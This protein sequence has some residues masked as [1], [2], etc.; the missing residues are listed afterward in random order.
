MIAARHEGKQYSVSTTIGL[1]PPNTR[2]FDALFDQ[3]FGTALP[4]DRRT[5]VYQVAQDFRPLWTLESVEEFEYCYVDLLETHFHACDHGRVLHGDISGSNAMARRG[6][7]GKVYGLLIDWDLSCI[8][9]EADGNT[10]SIPHL[11]TGTTSFMAIDL[12]RTASRIRVAPDHRYCHDLESFF[13]LLLWAVLHFDLKKKRHRN[14]THEEWIGCCQACSL[15]FK[16]DFMSYGGTW[17]RVLNDALNMWQSVV[18]R[19][20]KPLARMI[21]TARERSTHWND[22]N[23]RVFDD[24]VYAKELTFDV[25][26]QTIKQIPSK[27]MQKEK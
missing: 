18:K 4:H 10:S 27:R 17:D 16:R 20:V 13:W 24:D 21:Y 1:E 8:V 2:G 26:M 6:I 3:S 15:R 19:W 11:R 14:C 5:L 23:L 12:Q 9:D 7:G 25:F 22:D